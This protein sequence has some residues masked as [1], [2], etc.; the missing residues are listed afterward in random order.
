MWLNVFID[1][2]H[3]EIG[4]LLVSALATIF[5]LWTRS[6]GKLTRQ[7]SRFFRVLFYATHV[8]VLTVVAIIVKNEIVC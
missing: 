7:H 2:T 4:K 3:Y 5:A 8:H 1:R 6:I